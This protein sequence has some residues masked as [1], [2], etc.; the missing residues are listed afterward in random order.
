[1]HPK[2][3]AG[4][5]QRVRMVPFIHR[6]ELPRHFRND[7]RAS[8]RGGDESATPTAVCR[9]HQPQRRIQ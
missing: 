2:R 4:F 3:T 8:H 1:M 7:R 9:G 5:D 6:N